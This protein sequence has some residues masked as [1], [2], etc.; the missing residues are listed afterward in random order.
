[1][2]T[3]QPAIYEMFM[4]KLGIIA[5][6]RIRTS[7][8]DLG[9]PYADVSYDYIGATESLTDE[10]FCISVTVSQDNMN[11]A[12]AT[13]SSVFAGLD[14]SNALG[15]EVRT[16]GLI[17]KNE[18][19]SELKALESNADYVDRCISAF[20]F[21]SPLASRKEMVAFHNSRDLAQEDELKIFNSIVSASLDRKSNLTLEYSTSDKSVSDGFIAELFESSWDAGHVGVE[22]SMQNKILGT[23]ASTTETL[24]LKSSKKEYM[25]GGTVW[26]LSNGFKVVIKPLSSDGKI[27]Y[28]LALNGGYANIKNLNAGEGAYMSEILNLSRVAGVESGQFLDEV[29]RNGVTMKQNVSLSQFTLSGEAP[30]DRV[31]YLLKVLLAVMNDSKID[32]D[33]LD[34]YIKCERLRKEYLKGSVNER[35]S[36]IDNTMCPGYRYSDTRNADGLTMEFADKADALMSELSAKMNDGMLILV[37]DIDEKIVKTALLTYASG[38]RTADMTFVRQTVSYQPISGTVMHTAEGSVNSVDMVMSAPMSLTA[39]NYYVAAIASLALRKELANAVSRTG[40]SLQM[41]HSCG[42]EPQERFNLMISLNEASIDG[43]APNTAVKNPLLALAAVR[44]A[45]ADPESLNITKEELAAYKALLKKDVAEKKKTP[46][47]WLQRISMRYLDGKDFTTGCDAK[48][49]AVT[50]E[51][52]KTLL[53]SL[54]DGSKVEYIISKK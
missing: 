24:K 35:I 32:R 53:S 1:M 25:S 46:E 30:Y 2:N 6:E 52:V 5:G 51:K 36:Y 3:V 20:M 14:A 9:V 18:L 12:V 40:M 50:A 47:Y 8:R 37:G 22:A 42:K 31:D 49:D 21:N 45:L 44:S 39:D 19:K 29:R 26:T 16:A 4:S 7:L 10:M 33:A 13:V 23:S 43:F 15:A 27:C 28:S 48:I 34:Y 38:F 11:Q 54:V 17:Y 41:R